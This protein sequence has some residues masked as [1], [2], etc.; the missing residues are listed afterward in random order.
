MGV[1]AHVPCGTGKRFSFSI[2]NVLFGFR[3]SVLLGHPKINDVNNISCLTIRSTNEEIIWL[4]VAVDEVLL[5]DSLNS[6]QLTDV[7]RELQR[8]SIFR[9]ICFATMT[10]VL[11]ENLRLQ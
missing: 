7:R 1:D 11:I 5:V 10:T 6:R 4:D 8:A 2:R 3:I 9:T